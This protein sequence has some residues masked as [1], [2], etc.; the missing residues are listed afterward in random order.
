MNRIANQTITCVY[1]K[2]FWKVEYFDKKSCLAILN[3]IDKNSPEIVL[4]DQ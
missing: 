1:K 3:I 4:N 2:H